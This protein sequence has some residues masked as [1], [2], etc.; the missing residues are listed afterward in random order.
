M[1]FLP[2]IWG[3]KILA[4]FHEKCNN[5]V[6]RVDTG[7]SQAFGTKQNIQVL[8]ILDNGESNKENDFNPF[9]ILQ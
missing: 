2:Q 7:M 5:K 6:W 9:R 8:E 4:K 1:C 3:K